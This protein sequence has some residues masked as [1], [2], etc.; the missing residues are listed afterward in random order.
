LNV[1][2]VLLT[3]LV[4]FAAAGSAGASTNPSGLWGEVRRGP[5]APVCVAE[6][7]CDAPAKNV[8]LVFSR[9]GTVVRRAT[10]NDQGRYR[11][12]LAPG[13]YSVRRTEK[14]AV[15]RGLEPAQARVRA[16]RFVRV[17]FSIDTGIR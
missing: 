1:L 14:P 15:G 16:G 3:V 10:T 13:T 4:V 2:R 11:V 8:T 9:N 12:R 6:Q 7:P 17:D 5:I